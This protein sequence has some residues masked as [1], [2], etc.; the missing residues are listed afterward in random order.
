MNPVYKNMPNL[1]VSIDEDDFG[2]CFVI[3]KDGLISFYQL[4][5]F[6][7]NKELQEWRQIIGDNNQKLLTLVTEYEEKKVIVSED[8]E[9]EISENNDLMSTE[10]KGKKGLAKNNSGKGGN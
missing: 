4:D 2:N 9:E 8:R 6:L 10:K 5:P 1:I 7:L 3:Q